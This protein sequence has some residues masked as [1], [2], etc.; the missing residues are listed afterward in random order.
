MELYLV[1]TLLEHKRSSSQG[2]Q[3]NIGDAVVMCKKIETLVSAQEG[4]G[5]FIKEMTKVTDSFICKIL[6]YLSHIYKI[7][8]TK[9]SQN[10]DKIKSEYF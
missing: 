9:N 3:F 4:S 1:E 6:W 10:C 5:G 7:T 2:K 8:I